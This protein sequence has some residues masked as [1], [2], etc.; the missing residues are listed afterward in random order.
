MST[1][2]GKFNWV[3]QFVACAIF[4]AMTSTAFGQFGTVNQI[5]GVLIDGEG[6]LT[7]A[8]QRLLDTTTQEIRDSL[9]GLAD[10]A[11][12]ASE[13]RAISVRSIE[14]ALADSANNGIEL[15]DAMRYMAGIQR[16]KYVIVKPEINDILL[17]G[18]G[19]GWKVDA[20]GN[21]V[22]ESTGRPVIRLEDFIV[23]VRT[24]DAAN[25]GQGVSVSI[26]PTQQLSLIHISEPTRPY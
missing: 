4:L 16:I 10:S 8:T 5:G 7:E 13:L 21:V 23:A 14:K 12:E 11:R 6:V 15:T 25:R 20:K 3:T 18:P 9:E 17:V 1:Y 2:I 24:A 19:E 26:D 22:G